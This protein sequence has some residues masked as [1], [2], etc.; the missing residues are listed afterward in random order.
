MDVDLIFSKK[1]FNAKFI[2]APKIKI[3]DQN[4]DILSEFNKNPILI[5]QGKHLISSFHPELGDDLRIHEYFI[6]MILN[7]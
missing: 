7:E 5:K 2:R 6:K 3:L 4:L 1:I